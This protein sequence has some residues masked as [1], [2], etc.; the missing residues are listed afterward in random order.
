[1]KAGF[2]TVEDL[3]A[4]R[5]AGWNYTLDSTGTLPP[6]MVRVP[7][8]T[9]GLLL[10]GLDDLNLDVREYLIG[11]YEVTNREFK[12]FVDAGGYQV[13]EHWQVPFI[14]DGRELTW[15]QAMS[16]FHDQTGRP[17][18]AT[19]EA[20]TY[21]VGED[22]YPVTGVSWYEAAAYAR[23]AGG[24]LPTIFH[25]AWAARIRY[26][27]GIVPQ[28]NIE[29]RHSGPVA[30]GRSGGIGG[31]GLF[32]MAG[33]AREWTFNEADGHQR[34]ILGGG[35]DDAAYGFASATATSP[36][37][38]S[39]MNGL[40]LARFLK[41]DS[42][43]ALARRA[44]APPQRDFRSIPPVS[45]SV[46]SAYRR[47]YDYD[48]MPLNAVVEESDSSAR[49]WVKQRITF[50]AAYGNERVIA[51]LFLP[52]DAKPPYQTVIYF[53]GDGVLT[54]RSSQDLLGMTPVD[55]IIRS[56]RAVMYP[57]YKSTYE[58]G[59]GLAN[60]MPEE[61]NSYTEHVAAW[62]KDLRRSIDYLETRGDIDTTKL[63]YYGVSWGGRLGGIM[64]AVEPRL[65]VAVLNIA[66]LRAQKAFPEAEP[67]YFIPRIHI[68]VLMLNG[69]YDFYF[70]VE[71]SQNPMF[72]LLGT[73][74]SDKRHVIAEGS[75]YVPRP[76]LI[77]E[78]LD[79]LDRYLGPSR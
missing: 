78:T 6:G 73:P 1:V 45:D 11:K 3:V 9:D 4:P 76:V 18:P 43:V 15:E 32:D 8:G 52:A 17:G 24:E 64:L 58:R 48:R 79:W 31:F 49:D 19:W 36:F 5:N 2:D 41:S 44:V 28:S 26:S 38:R 50:D 27:A 39:P 29:G 53:P 22:D 46:Y 14:E 77:K 54:V 20:G 69:R 57:V 7:G 37:D 66:G 34:Y 47:L 63:A 10:W 71:S 65:K 30:V 56:G 75:H 62:A 60:S 16:R 13:P 70:P 25:W 68:P 51:Y 59:D 21:P 35:W 72:D 12:R 55:F 23:F 61:T 74:P 33:N 67:V 40:R 42:T